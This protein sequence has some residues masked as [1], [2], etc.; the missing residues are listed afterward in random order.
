MKNEI[1]SLQNTLSVS[2][3]WKKLIFTQNLTVHIENKSK[4]AYKRL[5]FDFLNN[6]FVG[7][8]GGN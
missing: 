7:G 1:C 4:N 2:S 6:F 3:S 8:G 5:F